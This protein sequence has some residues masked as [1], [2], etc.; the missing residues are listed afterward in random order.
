MH[1]IA[2]EPFGFTITSFGVMLALAFLAGWIYTGKEARRTGWFSEDLVGDLLFWL[3]VGG[4]VGARL[5]YVIVHWEQFRPDATEILNFRAGGMVSFGGFLGAFFAGW[6]FTRKHKVDFVQLADLC[7]PG[8]LLGQAVG[9][10]GCFL[11]AD[12]YGRPAPDLPWAVRFPDVEGS[13]L[14]HALRGQPL[15]PT[16]LYL[17]LKAFL[18][19]LVLRWLLRNR[20]F[21][22]Q[23]LAAAMIVYPLGRS[24]VEIWRYDA[25]ERGVYAGLST[26][27]WISIPL[28]IGGIALWFRFKNRPA[29]S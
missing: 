10:I 28:F 4:V 8:A 1:P 21:R 27:Q 2:F 26:A 24:I 19:F 18:C 29:V 12:D 16:Q 20:Q 25:V 23:V 22:G 13:M 17:L 14:P 11:V 7:L 3:M 6:I 15:H 9:R 5:L